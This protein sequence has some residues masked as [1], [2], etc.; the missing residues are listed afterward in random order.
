MQFANRVLWGEGMFLRPQHFQQQVLMLEQ[1]ASARFQLSLRHAWGVRSLSL[2]EQALKAGM[3]RVD[4]LHLVFRD[5]ALFRAPEAVPLPLSRDM[6]NL[7]QLGAATTLY[8]CLA[9]MQAYGGNVAAREGAVRPSRFQSSQAE[10]ADLYTQALP[11][12]LAVLKPDVRLMFEEENRDGYDA[13]PVC[14][15]EKDATG[16]W[17]VATDY[18]PPLLSIQASDW[19]HRMLRRWLDILL[20]RN[21]ALSAAL[22]E[23]AQNVMEYGTS[24]ISTFWLL[25][26]INRNFIR[27][28]HLSLCEPLHPEM[29]YQAVAEF[30]GEMQTFSSLYALSDVPV[31]R[32]EALFAVFNELDQQLRSLLETVISSRYQCIPL[33]SPRASIHLGRLES[34]RLVEGVDFYL[35]ISSELPASHIIENVPLKLKIGAPDDVERILNSAM[36]GVAL[37]HVLQTPS[38]IPVRVGNHY[39]ALQPQGDIF[40]RMLQSRSICIYVPQTL[41]DVSM[42]LFAVFR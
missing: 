35:S 8:A 18:I 33:H 38:A 1:E 19:L 29:L 25:H 24:D 26:T 42:E 30:C 39:F 2:D 15:L 16:Q 20:V 34:D 40:S 22:R 9:E 32:H 21:Q 28:R 4:R 41:S 6:S 17:C 14:R 27:L 7:P 31:Y 13:I 5:G 37:Q 23:R 11:A 3:L 12:D 36:R 10:V